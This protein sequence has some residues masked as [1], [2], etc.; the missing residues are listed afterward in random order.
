MCLYVRACIY[1]AILSQIEPKIKVIFILY[2]LEGLPTETT[3]DAVKVFV[4][5]PPLFYFWYI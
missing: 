1:R 5:L 4:R 2:M 3:P